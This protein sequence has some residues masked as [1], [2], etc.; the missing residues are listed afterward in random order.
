MPSQHLQWLLT[1]FPKWHTSEGTSPSFHV[2]SCLCIVLYCMVFSDSFKCLFCPSNRVYPGKLDPYL[3]SAP[4]TSLSPQQVFN[5]YLIGI[6]FLILQSISIN[7]SVTVRLSYLKLV[8]SKG[9]SLGDLREWGMIEQAR[10]GSAST[11]L[12]SEHGCRCSLSQVLNSLHADLT[13]MK[14]QLIYVSSATIT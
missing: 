8:F 12:D 10:W 2:G 6:F 9:M 7:I 11:F 5:K 14:R 1:P 3:F 4:N 13:Q